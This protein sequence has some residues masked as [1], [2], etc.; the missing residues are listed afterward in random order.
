MINYEQSFKDDIQLNTV[1]KIKTILNNLNIDTKLVWNTYSLD[2]HFFSC[3][4]ISV[5]YPMIKASGKGHNEMQ[6][7]ASAYGE[8]IERLSSYFLIPRD[9]LKKESKK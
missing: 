1:Y 7:E 8:L 9:T 3:D 2:L 4:I 6:A 5:N